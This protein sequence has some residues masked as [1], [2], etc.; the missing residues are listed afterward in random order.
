MPFGHQPPHKIDSRHSGPNKSILHNSFFPSVF[1][2]DQESVDL[3]KIPKKA[4][5]IDLP[6]MMCKAKEEAAS[7]PFPKSIVM[8]TKDKKI[9]LTTYASQ[10]CWQLDQICI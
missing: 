9:I 8:S 1:S 2:I 7:K 5:T 4:P 3:Y 10:G 6:I